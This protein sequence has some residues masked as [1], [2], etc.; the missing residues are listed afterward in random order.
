VHR[1]LILLAAAACLAFGGS[2]L[3][4]GKVTKSPPEK[5]G[6]HRIVYVFLEEPAE[7]ADEE[8]PHSRQL[9]FI[10]D[11][12]RKEL[13]KRSQGYDRTFSAPTWIAS[14]NGPITG[15]KYWEIGKNGKRRVVHLSYPAYRTISKG[16]WREFEGSDAVPDPPPAR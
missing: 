8:P 12:K 5:V 7:N 6:K 1:Y 13:P 11:G 3:A 10:I 2:V 15:L 4:A 9:Y 14:K 16:P